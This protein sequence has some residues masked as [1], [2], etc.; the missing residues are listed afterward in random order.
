MITTYIN[1]IISKLHKLENEQYLNSVVNSSDRI[2]E[3]V[4]VRKGLVGGTNNERLKQLMDDVDN[5][6][7]NDTVKLIR[8]L[9]EIQK[10]IKFYLI[11]V[12]ND[13]DKDKLEKLKNQLAEIESELKKREAEL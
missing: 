12:A 8:K 13:I 7:K 1:S 2:L 11:K 5:L 3:A 9:E 4:K 6:K 10:Y